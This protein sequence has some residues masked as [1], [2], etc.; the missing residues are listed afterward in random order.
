MEDLLPLL[1]YFD[2]ESH[3]MAA[4]SRTRSQSAAISCR[5][6]AGSHVTHQ[7]LDA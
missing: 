4:I 1:D 3:P 5:L 7:G 2:G 6:I